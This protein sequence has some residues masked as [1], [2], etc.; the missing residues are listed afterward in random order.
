[1]RGHSFLVEPSHN[2]LLV[3]DAG[4]HKCEFA[5]IIASTLPSRV[6]AFEPNGGLDVFVHPA[7]KLIQCALS[8]S[9]GQCVLSVDQNPEASSVC[10]ENYFL[11]S[12]HVYLLTR[13]Y[14]A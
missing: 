9:D 6:I 10:A 4:A 14:G 1:M 8:H 3:V 13:A 2:P 12:S 5:N 7:V 11:P